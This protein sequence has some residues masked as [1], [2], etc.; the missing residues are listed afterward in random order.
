MVHVDTYPLVVVD[1]TVLH[2]EVHAIDEQSSVTEHYLG[3]GDCRVLG[4]HVDTG[5]DTQEVEQLA[6]VADLGVDE[7]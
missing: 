5:L 3:V 2:G 4:C 6:A 1:E 7:G